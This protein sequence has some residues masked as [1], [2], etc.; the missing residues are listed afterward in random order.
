MKKYIALLLFSFLF[1]YGCTQ[2][3][4]KGPIA[5]IGG[6]SAMLVAEC[7]SQEYI[8]GLSDYILE[9]EVLSSESK[10]ENDPILGNHIFTYSDFKIDKYIKGQQIAGNALTLK[11][12]GGTV[13]TVTE[14]VEDSG[15]LA[16]GIKLTLYLND[17]NSSLST[18]CGFMGVKAPGLTGNNTIGEPPIP[19]LDLGEN[20]ETPPELPI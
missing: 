5:N 1:L 6:G 3:K 12:T 2:T 14:N 17:S 11:R 19:P 4:A 10:W 18:V 13:G 16:S 20:D 7:Q 9:G 15:S 8:S